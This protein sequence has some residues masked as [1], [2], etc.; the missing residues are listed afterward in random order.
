MALVDDV[1]IALKTG[2]PVPT[3]DRVWVL[4]EI[5]PKT[6]A[7]TWTI[8]GLSAAA[9]SEAIYSTSL[10]LHDRARAEAQAAAADAV[11]D[12]AL[13]RPAVSRGAAPPRA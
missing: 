13:Q 10:D 2:Q 9:A 3:D 11:V 1:L 4:V 6:G 7:R 8:H 5:D 12:S